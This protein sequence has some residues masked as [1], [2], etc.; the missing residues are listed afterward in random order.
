MII[1]FSCAHGL[2]GV[3]FIHVRRSLWSCVQCNTAYDAEDIEPYLIDVIQRKCMAL[4][5]QDLKCTKC[6]AVSH[7]RF[8]SFLFCY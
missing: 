7:R 1:Y 8:F 3:V 2:Y 4:T 5:L 6:K